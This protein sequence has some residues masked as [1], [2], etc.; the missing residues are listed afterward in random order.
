MYCDCDCAANGGK[1]RRANSQ[2]TQIDKWVPPFRI[3]LRCSHHLSGAIA[4]EEIGTGKAEALEGSHE[5]KLVA[6]V[7]SNDRD[8]Y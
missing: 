6:S 3:V 4:G 8:A 1:V 7:D 2:E 5:E